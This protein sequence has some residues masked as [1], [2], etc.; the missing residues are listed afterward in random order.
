MIDL[1]KVP[2][3]VTIENVSDSD[4]K[5]L[6]RPGYTQGFTLAAG[7]TVKLLAKD[8]YELVSY[9]AQESLN[10]GLVVTLPTEV[11]GSEADKA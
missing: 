3:I 8:S 2:G 6:S 1:S 11:V 4:I 5:I 10:E 9:L 7:E